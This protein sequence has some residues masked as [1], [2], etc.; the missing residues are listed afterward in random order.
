VK[1]WA[2]RQNWKL[3]CAFGGHSKDCL[4]GVPQVRVARSAAEPWREG[5]LLL[6]VATLWAWMAWKMAHPQLRA[7]NDKDLL[8]ME[9][10][11]KFTRVIA[12][13]HVAVDLGI[14]PLERQY[15]STLVWPP[16]L[17]A[18]LICLIIMQSRRTALQTWMPPPHPSYPLQRPH[19]HTPTLCH[20]NPVP[21]QPCVTPTLCHTNPVSHQPCATPTLCHTS[22]HGP[23][24]T[25]NQLVPC[26]NPR[27]FPI[28]AQVPVFVFGTIVGYFSLHRYVCMPSHPYLCLSI[29]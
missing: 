12:T 20:T 25:Q 10:V 8:C 4:A 18:I 16:V 14:R 7:P 3:H 27:S 5:I 2:Q 15:S 24:Q 6:I 1:T 26:S 13:L 28:V 23:Y 17:I 9:V 22:L 21:H 19:R 29:T 11:P